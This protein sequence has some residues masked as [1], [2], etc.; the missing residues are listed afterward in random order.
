MKETHKKFVEQYIIHNNASLAY[1]QAF[2]TNSKHS[3]S[4]AANLISKPAIQ[5]AIQEKQEEV[6]N[7]WKITCDQ[8][9]AKHLKVIGLYELKL[10][11]LQKEILTESEQQQLEKLKEIK[12]SDFNRACIE[13]A[14]IE[15][16][17]SEK[18]SVNYNNN[19][20]VIEVRLL[21]YQSSGLS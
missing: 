8:L 18:V 4:L 12:A 3:D 21:H 17:Y 15:G 13:L 11:L 16:L 1:R 2:N 20:K 9:V 6:R 7:R 5:L 10:D 14:R 19:L